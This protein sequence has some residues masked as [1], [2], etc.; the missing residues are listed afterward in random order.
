MKNRILI[1]FGLAIFIILI[2]SCAPKIIPIK[3]KYVKIKEDFALINKK[4]YDIAIQPQ[5]WNDPPQNL[6]NYFSLFYVIF[7]NKTKEAMPININS[8]VLID[9]KGEQYNLFDSDEVIQI[10]YGSN[11][12]YDIN[13]LLNY[14]LKDKDELKEE[15]ENRLE[16]MRNIKLKAFQ[17]RNIRPNAQESG[18]IFFEKFEYKKNSIFKI[19]YNNDVVEFAITG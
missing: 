3:S 7:R 10:M 16:G 18:Y 13:Y 12:Y 15:Y 9:V 1:I 5:S 11:Q 17:F 14:D 4:D 2:N 19:L 6:E 8:F